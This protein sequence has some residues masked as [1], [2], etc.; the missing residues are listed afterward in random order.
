VLAFNAHLLTDRMWHHTQT[1]W[2]P[3][4]GWQS[5]WEYKPMNSA[6]EMFNVYLDIIVRYPQVWAVELLA[7]AIFVWFGIRYRLYRWPRL[8]VFILTGQMQDKVKTATSEAV[9]HRI[10]STILTSRQS[11]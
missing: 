2:W 1:F 3:M 11:D 4:F 9:K 10:G 7:L 5:F 8:K 6:G